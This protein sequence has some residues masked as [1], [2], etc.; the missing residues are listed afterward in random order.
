MIVLHIEEIKFEMEMNE[1]EK[2]QTQIIAS[3]EK[4]YALVEND[5]KKILAAINV[6]GVD[7]ARYTS[8]IS[9][10]GSNIKDVL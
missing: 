7:L 10:D 9:T 2:K 4:D 3:L 8:I 6:S 5:K 1:L